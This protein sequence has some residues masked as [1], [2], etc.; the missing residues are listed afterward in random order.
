MASRDQNYSGAAPAFRPQCAGP[1]GFWPPRA[2]ATSVESGPAPAA[3][4]FDSAS[5]R[6]VARLAHQG[7]LAVFAV[8]FSPD[9]KLV[10]TGSVQGT[11]RVFEAAS[12]REVSL[13]EHLRTVNGIAFSPD[14]QLLVVQADNWLHAYQHDDDRWRPFANRH[15]PVIWPNTVHFAWSIDRC[16]RRVEVVRD[17][18]ENLHK[19]HR[20]NVDEPSESSVSSIA[21]DGDRLVEEWSG[22]L[23]LTFDAQG[24]IVPLEARP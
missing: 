3:R 15:V 5:G 1:G 13:V 19:L 17:V 6:E 18:P 4:V 20:I 11:V 2:S 23:G 7:T 14:G 16:P 12:G 21:G 10:A 8:A 24:R 9:G 22:R